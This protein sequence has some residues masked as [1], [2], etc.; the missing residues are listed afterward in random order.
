MSLFYK[1][2]MND[3]L[4]PIL[5]LRYRTRYEEFKRTFVRERKTVQHHV[6]FFNC[7]FQLFVQREEEEH[8]MCLN[9]NNSPF[10]YKSNMKE[11]SI[12]Q[13]ELT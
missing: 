4:S 13:E 9:N 8:E 2:K 5:A 3:C 10:F 12:S 6:M 7:V 1:S 11:W